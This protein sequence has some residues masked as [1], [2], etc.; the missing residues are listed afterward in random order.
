MCPSGAL[1]FVPEDAVEEAFES[2]TDHISTNIHPIRYYFEDTFFGRSVFSL[3]IWNMYDRT[4]QE[5]HCT[6]N[7]IEGWI[8]R[9]FIVHKSILTVKSKHIR[10][11]CQ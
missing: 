3:H 9:Q 1:A 8:I 5:P 10:Y 6:N 2:M 4:V 11:Y 7:N